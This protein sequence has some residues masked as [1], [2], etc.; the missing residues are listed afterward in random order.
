MSGPHRKRPKLFGFMLLGSFHG[1][2]GQRGGFRY[3]RPFR[4]FPFSSQLLLVVSRVFLD[5]VSDSSHFPLS[6]GLALF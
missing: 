1:E 5:G 4:P 2:G 3:V 6:M